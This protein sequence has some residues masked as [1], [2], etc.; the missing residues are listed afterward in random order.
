MIQTRCFARL[1]QGRLDPIDQRR[2]LPGEMSRA[3][4]K[5]NIVANLSVNMLPQ[6]KNVR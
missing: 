6:P 1:L 2:V 4:N 3:Q 5:A